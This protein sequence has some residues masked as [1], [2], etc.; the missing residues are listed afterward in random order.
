MKTINVFLFFFV[1]F[2]LVS[3]ISNAQK[4]FP[5]EHEKFA[6][7]FGSYLNYSGELRE[8]GNSME[9]EFIAFWE[10]DSLIPEYKNKFINTAQRIK[11]KDCDAYP[12]YVYFT[13]ICMEF[14]RKKIPWDQYELYEDA[15]IKLLSE[16]RLKTRDLN[17]L[18]KTTYDLIA[19]NIIYES[20]KAVW[21]INSSDY[22]LMKSKGEEA[23]VVHVNNTDLCGYYGKDSVKIKSTYGVLNPF[24]YTWTG[25][26]GKV[27][28][29]RVGMNPDTIYAELTNYK[30]SLRDTKFIADSVIFVNS[31]YFKEP[32]FG[33]LTD[34]AV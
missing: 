6:K 15:L 18:Q 21:T 16:K 4:A 22:S 23:Y 29:E 24:D 20:N 5:S 14:I 27:T 1:L 8:K 19:K 17:E 34:R 12:V 32:L 28:W 26:E 33:Q 10:S 3:I 13:S 11:A 7:E 30:M 31:I 9:K 2:N 25:K